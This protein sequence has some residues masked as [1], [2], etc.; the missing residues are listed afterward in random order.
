MRT[1]HYK[2]LL[3]AALVFFVSCTLSWAA[4][5]TFSWLPNSEANLAGYK[6]HYGTAS[7]T[8]TTTLDVGLPA[9]VNGRVPA[10]V[11]GLTEGVTYYF[12]ATAYDTTGMESGYSEEVVYSTPSV[13]APVVPAPELQSITVQPL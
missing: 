7:T 12:A 11:T 1:F 5:S 8:Y 13:I 4:D 6:I 9:L 3:S 2:L 10:T